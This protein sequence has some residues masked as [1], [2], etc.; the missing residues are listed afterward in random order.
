KESDRNFFSKEQIEC[1]LFICNDTLEANNIIVKWKTSV[2]SAV[3]QEGEEKIEL[4]ELE[5]KAVQ[6]TLEMPEVKHRSPFVLKVQI[7]C[8]EKVEVEKQW[9]YSV[10]PENISDTIKNILKNKE[11][12]VFDSPGKIK[13]IFNEYE[14]P[15]TS[16]TNQLSTQTFEGDLIIIGPEENARQLINILPILKDKTTEG[17]SVISFQKEWDI[18]DQFLIS[19]TNIST[20][21]LEIKKIEILSPD[22]PVFTE[23]NENDLSNWREDE[24]VTNFPLIKPIK[25]NFRILAEAEFST[26][27]LSEVIL[28]EGKFIFCQLQVIDKFQSEPIAQTLFANLIRYALIKQEPLQSAVIYGNPE[29]GIM[30]ILNSLSVAKDTTGDSNFVIACI[31]ED[32]EEFIKKLQTQASSHIKEITKNGGLILIF[33]TFPDAVVLLGIKEDIKRMKIAP[34]GQQRIYYRHEEIIALDNSS[35]LLWGISEDES[36]LLMKRGKMFK[37]QFGNADVVICQSLFNEVDPV[38]IRTMS[39]LITNFGIKIEKD[40]VNENGEANIE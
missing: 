14:I 37:L 25:G 10:F 11:I 34:L 30:E 13:Q 38:S 39:Q 7:I 1:T 3:I 19:L 12:G 22:H 27:A 24:V 21:P 6:I 16:L 40:V 2:F 15:F 26:S 5:G 8:D 18:E 17:I 4:G 31:D 33:A 29:T 32:S 20:Q 36:N 35:P 28:G 9:D 23:L